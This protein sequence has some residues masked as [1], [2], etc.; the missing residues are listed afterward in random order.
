MYLESHPAWGSWGLNVGSFVV[1]ELALVK[2]NKFRRCRG[3]IPSNYALLGVFTAYDVLLEIDRY[4]N[5]ACGDSRPV[6]SIV[7]TFFMDGFA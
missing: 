5:Q 1:D 3:W 7:F 6:L 4:K 2:K